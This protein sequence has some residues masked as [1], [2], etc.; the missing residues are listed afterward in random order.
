[1]EGR[2]APGQS[3]LALY[4]VDVKADPLQVS[5][6]SHPTGHQTPSDAL[7]DRRGGHHMEVALCAALHQ[8]RLQHAP[9]VAVQVHQS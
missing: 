3:L 2:Q 4:W 1:M 6:G 9:R 8:R 5:D 7:G